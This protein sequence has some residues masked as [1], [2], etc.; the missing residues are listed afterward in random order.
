MNIGLQTVSVVGIK[1]AKE[2]D[3]RDLFSFLSQ[4]DEQWIRWILE[5]VSV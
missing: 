2:K 1:P 4:E 5:D 3:V